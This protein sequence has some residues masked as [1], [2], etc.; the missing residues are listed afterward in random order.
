M[1]P[2]LQFVRMR[3]ASQD[4][5]RRRHSRISQIDTRV[6]V[7]HP[8]SE[9]AVAGAD[10]DFI[11]RQYTWFR[12]KSLDLEWLETGDDVLEKALPLVAAFLKE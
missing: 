9:V 4:A 11:R 8:A 2:F 1:I 6:T 3:D 10:T 12:P 5:T 7:S